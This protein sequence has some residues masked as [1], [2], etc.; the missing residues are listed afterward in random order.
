MSTIKTIKALKDGGVKEPRV[1]I[2]GAGMSGILM[3]INLLKAGL[4]NFSIYEK[5][6]TIGGTWR[7]T[8]ILEL[9]VIYHLIFI[10]TASSLTHIGR[11][12]FPRVQKFKP[13]LSE[14]L[15]STNWQVTQPLMKK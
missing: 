15:K 13:I 3:G 8:P 4:T 9:H 6:S 11:G 14:F 12:V 10:R 7:E 1:I 2:M 5:R